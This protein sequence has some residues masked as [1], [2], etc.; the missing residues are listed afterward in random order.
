MV[1]DSARYPLLMRLRKSGSDR[2]DADVGFGLP[3]YPEKA[4][5]TR[6]ELSAFREQLQSVRNAVSSGQILSGFCAEA[7][8]VK[9]PR[10]SD[11]PYYE[12]FMTFL[13]NREFLA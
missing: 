12:Y 5:R 6:P 10:S 2:F 8:N 13:F 11:P 4:A 9:S 3:A 7:Q 1:R